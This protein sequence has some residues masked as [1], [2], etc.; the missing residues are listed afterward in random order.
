M[1]TH[2]K[3]KSNNKSNYIIRKKWY[4]KGFFYLSCNWINNYI[5]LHAYIFGATT[6]RNNV[7]ANNSTKEMGEKKVG[8]HCTVFYVEKRQR[9]CI[10]I[11]LNYKQIF[12]E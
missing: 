6:Y 8:L 2:E 3:A 4:Y 11:S 5:K 1:N 12:R 7:F 9:I 10:N